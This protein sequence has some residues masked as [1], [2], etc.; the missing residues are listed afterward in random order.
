MNN[1]KKICF[2][3]TVKTWGG[4]EK[5]HFDMAKMF[6][7]K[8]FDVHFVA[9]KKS[10]LLDK[11]KTINIET[12]QISLG[13]LSFLNPFKIWGLV[14]I[15]RDKKTDCLIMNNSLDVKTG[16]IAA[17]I[18]GVKRIIYR[19][20]SA[21]PIRNTFFNRLLFKFVVSDVIANSEATKETINY[22]NSELF[23]KSKIKV[24][25]N[26]LEI[27]SLPPLKANKKNSKIII[28]NAARFSPEK[29]HEFIIEI[30]KKLNRIAHNFEIHLVG[31]GPQKKKIGSLIEKNGLQNHVKIL[32]FK[33]NIYEFLDSIDIFILTSKWEGFGFVLAEAMIRKKPIVAW[34]LSSIPEL[35]KNGKNGYLVTPYDTNMF[36]ELLLDLMNDSQKRRS[37]G[38]E[39]FFLCTKKFTIENTWRELTDFLNN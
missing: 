16:G 34:N 7:Q 2:F 38:E 31:D 5:W 35:V 23:P 29:G 33:N 19:R 32:G 9:R 20:G 1:K 39:G 11:L 14:R 6:C 8:G 15:F 37:F 36:T 22:H 25:Y 27:D 24:I 4:G 17:K 26:G 30:A 18:A 3:N 13:N 21:I 28:G 10:A 12:N